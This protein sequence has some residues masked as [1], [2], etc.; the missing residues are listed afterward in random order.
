M[1][2]SKS[3]PEAPT[4]GYK[5]A[6]KLD[7]SSIE[8]SSRKASLRQ[9]H[10]NVSRVRC[11]N[12]DDAV[13]NWQDPDTSADEQDASAES[14]SARAKMRSSKATKAAT[15][16]QAA[17]DNAGDG[18]QQH[19]HLPYCTHQCLRGLV[20]RNRLDPQ[21]P[22]R[23]LHPAT[24]GLRHTIDAPTLRILL[25]NQLDTDMDHNCTPLDIQGARGA[26]F[27]LTLASHGYTLVGKGTVRAFVP[28]LCHE[29]RIY[30]HLRKLQG[31]CV[32]VCLGNFDCIYPYEYDIDVEIVHFLLLSWGRVALN[33]TE[34][35]ACKEEIHQMEDQLRALGVE[36]EDMRCLNVLQD[37][38]HG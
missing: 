2:P 26:L 9:P 28:D 37:E 22:N 31:T 12:D 15:D 1:T 20:Q 21:C 24:K 4:S 5:P 16:A 33:W 17:R 36:H 7:L 3:K 34:Y 30:G 25:R 23:A 6:R 13:R 14:P 8:G 32:P 19:R 38:N 11:D 18:Q 10:A 29:G 35:F 27:K